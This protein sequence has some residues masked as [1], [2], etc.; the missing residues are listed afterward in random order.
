MVKPGD[1]QQLA[2][3]QDIIWYGKTGIV[4]FAISDY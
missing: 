1:K 4:P 2:R 3:F